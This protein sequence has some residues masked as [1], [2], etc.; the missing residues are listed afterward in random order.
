MLLGEYIPTAAT[1][2]AVVAAALNAGAV[3]DT[4]IIMDSVMLKESAANL[5]SL[6]CILLKNN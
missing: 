1:S 4:P 3:P 6:F 5:G 2:A